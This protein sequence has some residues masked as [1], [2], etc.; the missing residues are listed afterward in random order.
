M[1]SMSGKPSPRLFWPLLAL[2]L[3]FCMGLGLWMQ[4]RAREDARAYGQAHVR[5]QGRGMLLWL[6]DNP[7]QVGKPL[8]YL[9]AA[10]RLGG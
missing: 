2:G 10:A 4:D 3:V 5:P 9:R 1:H 6:Y 7:L 8:T